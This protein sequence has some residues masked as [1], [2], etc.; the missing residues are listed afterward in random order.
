MAVGTRYLGEL[1]AH[2]GWVDG[3]QQQRSPSPGWSF[4]NLAD[5]ARPV[6]A[7]GGPHRAALGEVATDGS[8]LACPQ[9][10]RP[11]VWPTSM[12]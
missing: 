6:D 1:G 12:R 4:A 5:P 3:Q 8:A 7:G 9:A 2:E 10:R 11:V